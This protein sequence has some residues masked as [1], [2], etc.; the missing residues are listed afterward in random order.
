MQGDLRLHFGIGRAEIVD[1]IEIKWPT[2]QK[3]ERYT[4]VKANQILII[5]EGEGILPAA[6]RSG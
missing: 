6:K 4:H 5:R 3:T 1:L 2:T